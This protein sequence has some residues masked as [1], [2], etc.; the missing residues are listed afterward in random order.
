MNNSNPVDIS[1]YVRSYINIDN[2]L[3]NLTLLCPN[4]HSQT[5]TWGGRNKRRYTGDLPHQI[6]QQSPP[7]KEVK[8]RTVK[9]IKIYQC[10]GCSTNIKSKSVRCRS[11]NGKLQEPKIQWLSAAKLIE[12]LDTMSYLELAR[13]IGVSDNA[14]RK[15]IRSCGLTPPT[16]HKK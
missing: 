11:C 1:P 8:A 4:C 7:P 9:P 16:R 14:I 10:I 6:L 15:H 13:Q 3:E 2:R 5:A 12:L